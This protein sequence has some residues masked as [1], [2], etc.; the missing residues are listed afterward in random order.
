[1]PPMRDANGR[2]LPRGSQPPTP[3]ANAGGSVQDIDMGWKATAKWFLANARGV[4]VEIGIFVPEVA[5]YAFANEFGTKNIPER[6]FIRSTFDRETPA[7]MRMIDAG[8]LNAQT[9]LIPLADAL[10]PAANHLR[11]AIINTIQSGI[12][13]NNAPS[14]I[15]A[16]GFDATLVNTGQMQ[17]AVTWRVVA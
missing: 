15:K 5:A 9:K 4:S 16:K 14:T 6:S 13:P 3:G 2:F 7:L 1:M 11:N 12:A 10:I 17:R 8:V